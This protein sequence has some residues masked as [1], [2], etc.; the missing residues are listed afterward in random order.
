M[1]FQVMTADSSKI[2]A[3]WLIAQCSLVEVDRRFRDAYCSM[4]RAMGPLKPS[5]YF[6]TTW[7]C[8]P[9]GCLSS[10]DLYPFL[11]IIS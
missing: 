9:Q 10:S 4:I 7:P 5:V 11:I 6:E 1:M 3:F 8:I 2:T